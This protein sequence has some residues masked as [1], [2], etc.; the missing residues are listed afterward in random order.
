MVSDIV[1]GL[2]MTKIGWLK[3]PS[4]GT[5]PGF[6]K[7]WTGPEAYGLCFLS[8]AK[9]SPFGASQSILP[10]WTSRDVRT[11]DGL[12]EREAGLPDGRFDEDAIMNEN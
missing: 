5:F 7:L 1:A 9:V 12:G 11:L 10:C 4:S 8:E 2:E 3:K 6:V